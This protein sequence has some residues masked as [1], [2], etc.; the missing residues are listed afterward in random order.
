M[1]APDTGNESVSDAHTE[2]TRLADLLEAEIRNGSDGAASYLYDL[3]E[4]I[5]WRLQILLTERLP[6]IIRLARSK[7]GWP[8]H[9]PF[10]GKQRGTILK[11]FGTLW[12]RDWA[13]RDAI[14]SAEKITSLGASCLAFHLWTFL[15]TEAA[16]AR[17]KPATVDELFKH[18]W[19]HYVPV[20]EREKGGKLEVL[21]SFADGITEEF[22][23][24]HERRMRKLSGPKD[25]RGRSKY[26]PR[27]HARSD[28]SRKRNKIKSQ[29]LGY[30]RAHPR[31][32]TFPFRELIA[33]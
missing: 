19:K 29:V 25:L 11:L 21:P 28:A 32:L 12:S 1:S 16:E 33:N 14:R 7:S 6:A 20:F 2:L 15:A 26:K 18:A 5:S 9:L 31:S 30:F 4:A 8:I 3:V 22:G 13:G 27:N 24:N 23:K 17:L 10:E